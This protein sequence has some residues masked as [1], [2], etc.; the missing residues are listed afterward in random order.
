MRLPGVALWLL[1]LSTVPAA[2][3]GSA[4][5]AARAAA[6]V[7]GANG[8]ADAVD[9]DLFSRQLYVMGKAA[10]MRLSASAAAVVGTGGLADEVTKNLV[11]SG[12]RKLYICDPADPDKAAE[13]VATLQQLGAAAGAVIEAASQEDLESGAQASVVVVCDGGL[14]LELRMNDL[15]RRTGAGFVAASSRGI[16]S[17]VFLDFGDRFEVHDA[18]GQAPRTEVLSRVARSARRD[19]LTVH[20]VPG[21]RHGLS[22][23]DRVTLRGVGGVPGETVWDVVSTP[24]PDALEVSSP[25]VSLSLASLALSAGA[26]LREVKVPAV[27]SFKPLSEALRTPSIVPTDFG[28]LSVSRQATLHALM[29]M[30]GTE[31]L[32]LARVAHETLGGKGR[33]VW[34]RSVERA[35]LEHGSGQLA[36][37]NAV[38]GAIAAQ[39]ALKCLTRVFTPAQQFVFFDVAEMDAALRKAKARQEPSN[40]NGKGRYAAQERAIGRWATQRLQALRVFVV[41]SG[42]IGCELVKLLALMGVGTKGEGEIVLTDP[43]TI[44]KS[45]LSRQMLF[46]LADVGRPKAVAAAER[47][48]EMNGD[49]RVDARTLRVGADSEAEGAFDQRFYSRLDAVMN[50]L[51]NLAA[52]RYMD[53]VAA[54]HQ[55]P[56]FD[57]GTLG[58]KGSQQPCI[59]HVTETYGGGES[60]GDEDTGDEIPLCTVHSF[61]SRPEHLVHWA[62]DVFFEAHLVESEAAAKALLRLLSG[63]DEAL[64]AEADALAGGG[65]E[66]AAAALAEWQEMLQLLGGPMGPPQLR[67]W[68]ER[69]FAEHFVLDISDLLRQHPI[70]SLDEDGDAFWTADR[71]PPRPMTPSALDPRTAKE[72]LR[73]K[74]ALVDGLVRLRLAN[75]G[76]DPSGRGPDPAGAGAPVPAPSRPASIQTELLEEADLRSGPPARGAAAAALRGKLDA[77]AE[78]GALAGA[79]R[80]EVASVAA[81]MRGLPAERLEALS[82][83]LSAF[84][85]V[86]FEKDDDANGHV[87]L[88]AAASCLRALNYGLAEVEALEVKRIAGAITPAMVTTTALVSGLSAI[89]LLKLSVGCSEA[90]EYRSA[91]L[92]LAVPLLALPLPEAPLRYHGP[93]SMDRKEAQRPSGFSAWTRLSA[94]PSDLQ[95]AWRR[96]LPWAGAGGGTLGDL[97]ALVEG[98]TGCKVLSV[99]VGD[100]VIAEER[101]GEPLRD[102]L[103]AEDAFA[104][105]EM[106]ARD[107]DG[108]ELELPP[109]RFFFRDADKRAFCARE[110]ARGRVGAP[111]REER[112]PAAKAGRLEVYRRVFGRLLARL[113][114]LLGLRQKRGSVAEDLRKRIRVEA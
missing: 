85:A 48:R 50:A 112:A 42:A 75:L 59:P 8:P 63:G 11:L 66:A 71:I 108:D 28:K 26:T 15:C 21:R 58:A 5:S 33:F 72:A 53:G 57:S 40:S 106:V 79:V 74:R 24:A 25:S 31:A 103:G 67:D 62:R 1:W 77:A 56:L 98:R 51:D 76:E 95:P 14:S 68:A 29:H 12:C 88:L 35:F 60:S 10:Q 52:R 107:A 6:A 86:D 34:D 83:R 81:A 102:A 37:V 90:S 105:L 20:C 44:E 65:P 73:L 93:G 70:D 13:A 23:G 64:A 104:E 4:A 38:A 9:E 96:L 49:L 39:E 69:V 89:E 99:M 92:N 54:R 30:E 87:A 109:L 110:A 36:P 2:V 22:R 55:L 17:R 32:A 47:A 91:F 27:L 101:M 82:S 19:S 100:A 97:V 80:R 45:N 16:F 61:P 94:S 46:S 113:L 41:G 114:E 78:R 18:N 7:G 3:L 84:S 111:E 43:D